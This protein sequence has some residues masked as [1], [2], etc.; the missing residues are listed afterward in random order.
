MAARAR[1]RIQARASFV[2]VAP[3]HCMQSRLPHTLLHLCIRQ[4]YARIAPHHTRGS[5]HT[6]IR[7]H[8]RT[9]TR[10]MFCS[11]FHSL[12]HRNVQHIALL[13][14]C[15]MR[16]CAY[17]YENENR[18]G[19][20][21]VHLYCLFHFSFFSPLFGS[22]S[23]LLLVHV[24]LNSNSCDAVIRRCCRWPTDGWWH[25]GTRR[26]SHTNYGVQNEY[27]CVSFSG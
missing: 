1:E 7:T 19:R 6:H 5:K 23:M 3:R 20:Q 22:S 11:L 14:V 26:A 16:V 4:L 21:T 13:Y 15:A 17:I 2:S 8:T 10:W 12:R 25:I 27:L 24:L 18:Y 9:R